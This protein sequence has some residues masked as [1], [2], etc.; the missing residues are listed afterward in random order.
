[1]SIARCN[2]VTLFHFSPLCFCVICVARR[3]P[4]TTSMK[5]LCRKRS[6][7]ACTLSSLKM[8]TLKHAWTS[9]KTTWST[10]KPKL[11]KPQVEGR[12]SSKNSLRGNSDSSEYTDTAVNKAKK[13]LLLLHVQTEREA[14]ICHISR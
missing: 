6:L 7:H 1:M 8:L 14:N 13:L 4:V 10:R 11:S 9:S 5:Y 12:T 2:E 3:L